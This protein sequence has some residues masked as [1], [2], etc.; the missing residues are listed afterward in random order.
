MASKIAKTKKS[1]L[2]DKFA[3]TFMS[4]YMCRLPTFDTG[5]LLRDIK[6][7]VYS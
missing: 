4:K 5:M 7:V 2:I 3:V 6:S 1:E